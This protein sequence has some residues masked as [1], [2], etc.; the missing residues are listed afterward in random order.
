MGLKQAIQDMIDVLRAPKPIKEEPVIRYFLDKTKDVS[1]FDIDNP[2]LPIIDKTITS[3]VIKSKPVKKIIVKDTKR[4]EEIKEPIKK[5]RGRPK[6]VVKEEPVKKPRGRP[7][8][9][10]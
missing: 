10:K 6:K 2:R 8:K 1:E 3:K 7:P 4:K 9:K 5:P